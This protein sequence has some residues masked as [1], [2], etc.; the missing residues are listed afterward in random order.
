[1]RR[2]RQLRTTGQIVQPIQ[3]RLLGDRIHAPKQQI[4]IIRLPAPQTACQFSPDEVRHCTGAQVGLVAH[5]VE[6]D[7]GLDELGELHSVAC[8]AAEGHDGGFVQL[9][10]LV[11]A[12][13][14]DGGTTHGGFAGGDYGEVFACY[15]EEDF[16]G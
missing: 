14:Q 11:V 13:F 1:M 12:G 9:A 2:I 8:L 10:G 5:G 15:S 4:H 3:T 16:L 6:G 7:V